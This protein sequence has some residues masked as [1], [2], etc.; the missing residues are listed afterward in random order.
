MIAG[1]KGFRSFSRRW[2]NYGSI[3]RFHRPLAVH[4]ARGQALPLVAQDRESER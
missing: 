2:P 3:R 1:A 4:R